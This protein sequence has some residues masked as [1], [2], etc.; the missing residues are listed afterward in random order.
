MPLEP[1]TTFQR[2]CYHIGLVTVGQRPVAYP[3]VNEQMNLEQDA[4]FCVAEMPIQQP[5]EM[6]SLLNEILRVMTLPDETSSHFSWEDESIMALV[7]DSDDLQANMA[8]SFKKP[9]V[10][11]YHGLVLTIPL[12]DPVKCRLGE[13]LI[14]NLE[15]RGTAYP[16]PGDTT[17]LQTRYLCLPLLQRGEEDICPSNHSLTGLPGCCQ[18]SNGHLQRPQGQHTAT[19]EVECGGSR[20]RQCLCKGQRCLYS[21]PPPGEYGSR[22][23][24]C[25]SAG[26]PG[27]R[28]GQTSTGRYH[29]VHGP[30]MSS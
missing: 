23:F 19:T 1:A 12:D 15:T 20:R 26:R 25:Q 27:Y 30:A 8:N 5:S 14:L 4:L 10:K 29:P 11:T 18:A 28:R 6:L 7:G 13:L 22:R 2:G 17:C 16:G 9:S 3:Q 21:V 24:L